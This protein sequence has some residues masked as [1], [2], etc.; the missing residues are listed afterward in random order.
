MNNLQGYA[1]PLWRL[2]KIPGKVR[3][4]SIHYIYKHTNRV[5]NLHIVKI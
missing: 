1:R 5:I 4:K 3:D 2:Y